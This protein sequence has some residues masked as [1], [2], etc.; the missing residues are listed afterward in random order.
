M[1]HALRSYNRDLKPL[2]AAKGMAAETASVLKVVVQDYLTRRQHEQLES[3]QPGVGS[4]VDVCGERLAAYR[5]DAGRV[6]V[7]SPVCTHM[8]CMVHWNALETSWDCP[9]HGSRFAPDGHVI[10]GP[11]IEPLKTKALPVE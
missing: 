9:C 4:I 8:K 11:A 10:A 3:L 7:V 1:A 5:D 6:F 2:K